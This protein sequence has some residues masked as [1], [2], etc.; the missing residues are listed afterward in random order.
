MKINRDDFKKT[1]TTKA[2][3]AA[4]YH[5][6]S[7]DE[8]GLGGLPGGVARLPYSIRVLLE[9]A[10]RNL[11]GFKVTEEDV[12]K[13]LAWEP[14]PDTQSEIAFKPARVVLQDF[15]GVPVDHFVLFDFDGTLL[16]T[17]PDLV[18][19]VKKIIVVMDHTSKDGSPKFIPEC[20]LPL[21]G[22]NV[23]DMIITNLGVFHRQDHDSPFRLIELAPGVTKED[24]AELTTASY[25][26]ALGG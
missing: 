21:T 22:T 10:V 12:A 11:D 23:V 5:L 1:L 2:G 7:L 18:A 3:A 13:I 9:S 8:L 16:D 15:T 6:P 20:T 17:A 25:E 14:N 26:V 19:G 24:V 4:M